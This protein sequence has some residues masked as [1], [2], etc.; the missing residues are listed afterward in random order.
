MTEITTRRAIE[1]CMSRLRMWDGV[2]RFMADA[3]SAEI[4]RDSG[5]DEDDIDALRAALETIISQC[6]GLDNTA[7]KTV[8]LTR[9]ENIKGRARRAIPKSPRYDLG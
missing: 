4:A 6:S 2:R 7:T 1:I 8:L 3:L 9:L 5:P